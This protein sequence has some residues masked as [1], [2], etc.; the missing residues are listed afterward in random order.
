M[1]YW[2]GLKDKIITQPVKLHKTS[3]LDAHFSQNMVISGHNI[4]TNVFYKNKVS[5]P[6]CQMNKMIKYTK[7]SNRSFPS[8]LKWLTDHYDLCYQG[9]GSL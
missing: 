5:Q 2:Q 9:Y 4:F 7:I 3:L 6:E 8:D 1:K